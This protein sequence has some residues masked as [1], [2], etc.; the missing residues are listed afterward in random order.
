M[1]APMNVNKTRSKKC[2]VRWQHPEIPGTITEETVGRPKEGSDTYVN[3]NKA[4]QSFGCTSHINNRPTHL[5]PSAPIFCLLL[6]YHSHSPARSHHLSSPRSP[7]HSSSRL[8]Y[9][10]N[11]HFFTFLL[12]FHYLEQNREVRK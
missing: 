12:L 10:I 11:Q 3:D 9:I 1:S 5:M 7:L 2:G 8:V 6:P 4:K